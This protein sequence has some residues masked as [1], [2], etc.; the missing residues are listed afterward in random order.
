MGMGRRIRGA[1]ALI[2][3]AVWPLAWHYFAEFVRAAVYE[4]VLHMVSPQIEE[5]IVD[6]VVQY[7]VTVALAGIGLWLFL[8]TGRASID[9]E[10]V[11]SWTVSFKP[12]PIAAAF[13]HWALYY[14]AAMQTFKCFNYAE[15]SYR[16]SR[17]NP[18]NRSGRARCSFEYRRAISNAP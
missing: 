10:N 15:T 11:G 9:F 17:H 13:Y 16:Y 4:R 6:Y 7:G 1:L 2:G 14:Y 3:A 12:G 8:H 5:I 18:H